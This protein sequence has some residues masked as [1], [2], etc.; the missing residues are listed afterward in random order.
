MLVDP[1]FNENILP[2]GEKTYTSFPFM[3][4]LRL[5]KNSKEDLFTAETNIK[6]EGYVS[7]ETSRA[8]TM[9]Q[10][11]KSSNLF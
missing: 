6:Y 4:V 11:E 7:R 1:C 5:S 9:L 2:L 8:K 10:N 3:S